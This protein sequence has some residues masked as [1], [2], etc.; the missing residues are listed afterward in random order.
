M[1]KQLYIALVLILSVL[2]VACSSSLTTSGPSTGEKAVSESLPNKQAA[3]SLQVYYLDVGQG[4][5]TLIKTPKGQ[6]ILIDGGDNHKGQTVV[7]YL[8]ELGVTELDVVIATHPDADHIGGLDT[9]IESIPTKSVYAPRVS[10]TTKSYKDFLLAVKNRGLKIKS[11][12]AGL[13]LPLEDV[14]AEFVAPVGEYGK[15]LNAWSAVLHLTYGNTSFL[16]TGDAEKKSEGD[17]V[18]SGADLRADVYKV[19]HHGS[20]T[21]SSTSF[22]KAISPKYA[23]ISVGKD[24]KYSHPKDV[25][26][27][28]LK[29]AK[30]KVFRT[31]I[32][33]TITATSDGENIKFETVR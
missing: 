25:V 23:V 17:M 10:H 18:K 3:G 7:D 9:V 5:A 2:L 1:K 24:N 16:F 11:A 26:L 21:S 15:D 14:T 29:N 20:D 13:M 4:D 19:G 31:D 22:L 6:H 12:K 27:E 32:Q 30:V 28:R 33:G 8:E